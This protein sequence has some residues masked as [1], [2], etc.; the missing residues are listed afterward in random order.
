MGRGTW[1]TQY[2][3]FVR[4]E[5]SADFDA[6]SSKSI[7]RIVYDPMGNL[8]SSYRDIEDKDGIN[9]LNSEFLRS[10]KP[11]SIK[12]YKVTFATNCLSVGFQT[13][14]DFDFNNVSTG[15]DYLKD[16]NMGTYEFHRALKKKVFIPGQI[17]STTSGWVIRTIHFKAEW[18]QPKKGKGFWKNNVEP[19]VL[20]PN[21]ADTFQVGLAN[22]DSGDNK[23]Y[24]VNFELLDY[25]LAD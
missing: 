21:K 19:I 6:N 10:P 9:V 24:Y 2:N 14:G 25:A 18:I 16:W 1:S 5:E 13:Y 3:K 22:L 8:P 23:S 20:S 4:A 15:A 12:E 17:N 7:V 11:I